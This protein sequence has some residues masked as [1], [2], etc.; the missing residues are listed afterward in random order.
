MKPTFEETGGTYRREG[1]YLLPNLT[2]P[3][4]EDT[5]PFG[6][7]G[8]MRLRYLKEHCRALYTG[9]QISGKLIAHLREVDNCANAMVEQI[10]AAMGLRPKAPTRRSKLVTSSA[11]SGS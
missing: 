4:Q 6:K 2:L 1:D 11:G 7:Y 3:P 9:L 10:V 8:R 5:H